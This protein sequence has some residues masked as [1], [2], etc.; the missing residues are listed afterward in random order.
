MT[1]RYATSHL[2]EDQFEPGSN[3]TVLRNLL[4]IKT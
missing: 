3:G 2:T 4:G 1:D